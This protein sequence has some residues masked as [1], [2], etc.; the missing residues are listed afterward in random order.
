MGIIMR[1][2]QGRILTTMFQWD[3]GRKITFDGA[4]TEL[5]TEV[6]FAAMYI[7]RPAYVARA[8]VENG[9]IVAD[10]PDE[11]LAQDQ[12]IK[13]YLVQRSEYGSRTT[14]EFNLNIIPRKM[15]DNYFFNHDYLTLLGMIG[16]LSELE[17]ENKDS[18]VSA[19]NEI[20]QGGGGG[21]TADLTGVV[22]CLTDILALLRLAV[23]TDAQQPPAL[24]AQ[25]EDDIEAISGSSD[26]VSVE[27][28]GTTAVIRNLAGTSIT[29]SGTTAVIG[30]T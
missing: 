13:V 28:S 10:V 4:D 3:T 20:A 25:L 24:L 29:F 21:G 19:I 9:K 8:Y 1:D 27:Y 18:L 16:S 7:L 15:P 5:T 2:E 23:Y 22:A 12:D 26:P 11:I 30:G 17:T 14:T 6:H